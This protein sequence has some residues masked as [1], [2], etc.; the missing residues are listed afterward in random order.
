M[1]RRLHIS[2][3]A[4]TMAAG[5]SGSSRM[6]CLGRK[7]TRGMHPGTSPMLGRSATPEAEE[8][9]SPSTRAAMRLCSFFRN[10]PALAAP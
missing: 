2:S 6:L 4:M 5:S 8:A 3:T 1:H 10:L 7:A 9:E